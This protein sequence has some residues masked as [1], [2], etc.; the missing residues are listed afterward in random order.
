MA[1]IF[2]ATVTI[3][4][5]K[6]ATLENYNT[7]TP[8]ATFFPCRAIFTNSLY[9]GMDNHPEPTTVYA[10][11]LQDTKRID[12]DTYALLTPD[13]TT[14]IVSRVHNCGCG[15]R[16]RSWTPFRTLMR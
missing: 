3:F 2:P 13:G 9:V 10:T 6:N 8:A 1:D 7:N 11:A 5:E 14:I 15:S 4:Q 12:A 16:L